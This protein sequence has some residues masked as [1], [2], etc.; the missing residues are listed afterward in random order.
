[1]V[2]IPITL[3]AATVEV[4]LRYGCRKCG[5]ETDVLVRGR[6]IASAMMSGE[7]LDE[8][9]KAAALKSA[10][11][12]CALWPCPRCGKR[13]YARWAWFWVTLAALMLVIMGPGMFLFIWVVGPE[14][15]HQHP[16]IGIVILAILN[17]LAQI[18]VAIQML[19]ELRASR[20]AVRLRPDPAEA[21]ADLPRDF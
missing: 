4:P 3:Q 13:S 6:G 12:R 21:V 15:L 16:E 8:N 14:G 19:V 17:A 5:F 18:G 11:G 9:A 7:E 10:E 20:Y 2:G 1:M